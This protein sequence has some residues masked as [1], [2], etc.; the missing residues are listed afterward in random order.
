MLCCS[1]Q[2]SGKQ[3]LRRCENWM[4]QCFVFVSDRKAK[5]KWNKSA[6]FLLF[7]LSWPQC[8]RFCLRIIPF[9]DLVIFALAYST[10]L[11]ASRIEFI[12]IVWCLFIVLHKSALLVHN[13]VQLYWS[14]RSLPYTSTIR[15]SFVLLL[16]AHTTQNTT[17][18][19]LFFFER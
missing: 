4:R 9:D 3:Q 8:K 6:A 12:W 17:M 11:W 15:T 14:G 2:V 13:F 5:M 1:A 7:V 16:L 19:S 10:S 18:K